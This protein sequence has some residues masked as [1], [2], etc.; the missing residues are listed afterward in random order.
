VS[1]LLWA[2]FLWFTLTLPPFF[3]LSLAHHFAPHTNF[4]DWSSPYFFSHKFQIICSKVVLYYRDRVSRLEAF[5]SK[6]RDKTNFQILILS[7]CRKAHEQPT[8]ILLNLAT[9]LKHVIQ[10]FYMCWCVQVKRVCLLLQKPITSI[11]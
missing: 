8:M 10:V 1:I 7:R 4:P 5:C 9:A 2:D 3:T 11:S 6:I